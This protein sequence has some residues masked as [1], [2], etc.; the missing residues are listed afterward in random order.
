MQ[1]EIG[2]DGVILCSL[3]LHHNG[4]E[5]EVYNLVLDT[6]A[7]E[8]IIYRHAVRELGIYLEENDEFV[9]MRGIGGREPAF[10]K[11][12]QAVEFLGFSASDFLIDFGDAMEGEDEE[13]DEETVNGLLGLDVLKAGGFIIDL[14]A[15]EV[16]QKES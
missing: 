5:K 9:F 11:S 4:K 7:A 3:K 13:F 16:Y 15:M 12:V 10:R 2:A 6:G 14:K 1:I 8:T